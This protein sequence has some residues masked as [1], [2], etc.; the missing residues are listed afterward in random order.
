MITITSSGSFDNTEA[1]LKRSI[2]MNPRSIFDKY[3]S[4][5]VQALSNGTPTDTGLTSRSWHYDIEQKR[6]LTVI[7]FR[8]SHVENGV[9][10]AI[11]I[12]YGHGTRTGGY[13]QGRD[14]INP[15][16]QPVMDRIAEDAW[17]E[18]TRK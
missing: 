15:A 1:F 11:L 18:V 9:P 5:G 2:A 16:I 4:L 6:G 8:N 17:K 14:Y 3:G 7:N 13:V 12:Q 10:I